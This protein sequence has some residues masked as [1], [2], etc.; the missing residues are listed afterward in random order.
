MRHLTVDEILD[1][2]SLTELNDEA[3]QLSAA[4]NGHI[5]NCDKCL[6]LV[7]SFQMI[8]DEFM[9]LNTSGDF[10]GFVSEN[11]LELKNTNKKSI[12]IITALNELDGYR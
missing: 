1:F 6:K 9:K 3:M 2:V 10:K 7:R 8:Y 4:V 12:E 5:R 11:L